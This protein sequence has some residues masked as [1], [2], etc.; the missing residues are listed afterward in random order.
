MGLRLEAMAAVRG[1]HMGHALRGGPLGPRALCCRAALGSQSWPAPAFL[2]PVFLRR[3]LHARRSGAVPRPALLAV[4]AGPRAPL[5]SP[6]R[7]GRRRGDEAPAVPAA[8]HL[9]H[10]RPGGARAASARLRQLSQ[11]GSLRPRHARARLGPAWEARHGGR[12]HRRHA[13]DLC[14]AGSARLAGEECLGGAE[15]RGHAAR[16]RAAHGPPQAGLLRL[17]ALAQL[18]EAAGPG[19]ARGRLLRHPASRARHRADGR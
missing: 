9:R 12:V 2:R 1:N 11:D 18:R 3:A 7:E 19:G 4:E 17:E 6:E 14:L 8:A 15:L 16:L 10:R 5:R 13:A